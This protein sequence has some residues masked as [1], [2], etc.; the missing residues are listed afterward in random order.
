[1]KFVHVVETTKIALYVTRQILFVIFIKRTL[2]VKC[3]VILIQVLNIV[4][5]ILRQ[6]IVTKFQI[7]LMIE[8]NLFSRND[9]KM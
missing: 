6:L 1:M 7:L 4:K 2:I 5:V 9:A 8:P 3:F